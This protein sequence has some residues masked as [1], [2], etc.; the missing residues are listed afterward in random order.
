[1]IK[2]FLLPPKKILLQIYNTM[3]KIRLFEEEIVRRWPKQEMRSP[4]HFYTGEEGI[5]AGVCTALNPDDQII[6]YYRGHGHYLAKGGNPQAFIAEM[7][8]KVTGS[9]QGKGGS[10][11]ISDPSVGFM[12]STAI[13][14]GG[15]PIA[16]GLALAA[17][18]KKTNQVIVC[19]FGDAATE[20][21]VFPES[22]NFAALKKLPIVYVCENNLYAVTTHIKKRRSEPEKILKYA[23]VFGLFSEQV[24]G[25]NS[26]KVYLAAKKAIDRARQGLGPTLIEALTYR[27][28]EHVGEKYDDF[29]GLRTKK[30]LARWMRKDPI[31]RLEKILLKEGVLNK[32]QILQIRDQTKQLVQAAFEFGI[33]SPLPKESDLLT[34]VS[35]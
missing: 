6:S 35:P 11:L 20:E 17:K 29:S 13:V 22:L 8:C 5:A 32:Q 15:I 23:D 34:N 9:N 2:R 14:G 33:K 19:F 30:E 10:M 27:W 7:Y 21:G 28:H 3:V 12:G 24:D 4:P 18:M 1:M 25:N 16:T 31:K 26:S